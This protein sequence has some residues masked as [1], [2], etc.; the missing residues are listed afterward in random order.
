MFLNVSMTKV[1]VLRIFAQSARFMRPDQV[2]IQLDRSLDRRSLYSYLG[3]LRQQGL[4]ERHPNSRR[5][6]LAYRLTARGRERLAY[7]QR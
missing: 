3:R 7:L 5:G 6:Q 4:I 1:E 2:W